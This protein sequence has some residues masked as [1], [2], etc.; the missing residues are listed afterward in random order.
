MIVPNGLQD[1]AFTTNVPLIPNMMSGTKHT[2]LL[3]PNR[4]RSPVLSM[5]R[6]WAPRRNSNH[7]KQSLLNGN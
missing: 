6:L 5:G 3:K 2:K 7:S 4:L 1:Q